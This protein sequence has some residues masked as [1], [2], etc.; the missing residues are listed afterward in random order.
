M[1]IPILN[2]ERG[3]LLV[4]AL[5]VFLAVNLAFAAGGNVPESTLSLMGIL[6]TLGFGFYFKDKAAEKVQTEEVARIE[7]AKP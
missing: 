7:A 4:L 2:S 6:L 1:V 5:I 3:M